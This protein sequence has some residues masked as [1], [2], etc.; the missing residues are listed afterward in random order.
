MNPFCIPFAITN[1]GGALLAMDLGFM[2]PNYSISTA[3]ATGNYCITRRAGRSRGSR[4]LRSEATL[5]VVKFGSGLAASQSLSVVTRCVELHPQNVYPQNVQH[6][7]D[8]GA[9]WCACCMWVRV[10]AGPPATRR[11]HCDVQPA[12]DASSP[13]P[14]RVRTAHQALTPLARGRAAPRTTSG[15]ATR[16]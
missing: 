10:R 9:L 16:T 1:M 4:G 11:N 5:H 6:L 14:P 7:R 13:S 2:G 8:H 3:C 15:A 12:T